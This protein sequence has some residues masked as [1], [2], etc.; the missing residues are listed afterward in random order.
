MSTD[1]PGGNLF[2]QALAAYE[3]DRFAE[4]ERLCIEIR[5]TGGDQF[6]AARLLAVVQYRLGRRQEALATYDRILATRPNHAEAYNNRGVLL[7]ELGRFK[8]SLASYDKALTIQPDYAEAHN[9]RG[10]VLQQLKRPE[11]AVAAYDRALEIRADYAEAHHNRGIALAELKRFDDAIANYDRALAIR[12]SYA[13]ALYSRGAALQ[14]LKHLAQALASYEQALAIRPRD[15]EALL[16]RSDVL[17]QLNRFEEALAS[18]DAAFAARPDLADAHN[19][20]GN[21]L[22]ELRRFPEAL[23]S[24]AKAQELAPDFAEAHWNEAALRLLTG[25]FLRGW[26]K[27][28]WRWQCERT[29]PPRRDFAKPQ[30]DGLGSLYDKTILLHSAGRLSEAIQFC[31]YVPQLAARGARILLDP[32]PP[33]RALMGSLGGGPKILSEG[34]RIEFDYHCP[35]SS[36]PAAFGTKPDTIPSATPYLRPP[37]EALLAWEMRI[38][39]KKRPRIGLAWT[40]TPNDGNDRLGSIELGAFQP[41]F[42]LDATFLRLQPE[43]RSGDEA[44]LKQHDVF[45]PTQNVGNFSDIAALISRLDL[46]ISIDGCIAH[47]TGAI[48]KPVW[49]LLAFTPDWPW[50]LGRNTSTWYPTARLYRQIKPGQW[51]E[52][53][54]RLAADLPAAIARDAAPAQPVRNLL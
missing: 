45:D 25:E 39:A 40:S 48:G 51:G 31:R 54:A 44:L 34:E 26:A 41:L 2:K 28:E 29:R 35:F 21:I 14:E 12:P 38:G 6:D 9:N 32:P 8:E 37:T 17:L 24:F 49:V 27:Y 5:R 47:L 18:C 20:R 11:D 16:R 46:V 3:A 53:V 43:L 36:L 7:Q 13:D 33:L 4:A 19:I 22:R 10:V 52:V 23:A 30:W 42:A 50:Q 1:V 15:A